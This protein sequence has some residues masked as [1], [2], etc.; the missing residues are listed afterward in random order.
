[1]KV[2]FAFLFTLLAV[3]SAQELR[4]NGED[5]V[6]EIQD[7]AATAAETRLKKIIVDVVGLS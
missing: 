2:S 5:G 3:T 6:D 7:V 4:G 1:M